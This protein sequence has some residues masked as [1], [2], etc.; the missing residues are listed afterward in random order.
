[1]KQL[2]ILNLQKTH[3]RQ[4]IKIISKMTNKDATKPANML[5]LSDSRY[6]NWE[7]FIFNKYSSIKMS[8]KII[9]Q[10]SK[11]NKDHKL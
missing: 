10:Q 11:N 4:G 1:L 7:A 3:T 6:V 8:Q 2:G 9:Q 5:Y